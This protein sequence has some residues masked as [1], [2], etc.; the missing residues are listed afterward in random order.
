MIGQSN[1]TFH[2]G[3]PQ[4]VQRHGGLHQVV[5]E[6]AR[7]LDEE[8][9]QVVLVQRGQHLRSG[10]GEVLH[11]EAPSGA[12]TALEKKISFDGTQN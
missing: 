11:R 10:H 4:V 2:L 1:C 9:V 6:V 7:V 3:R 8:L 5:G 12:A